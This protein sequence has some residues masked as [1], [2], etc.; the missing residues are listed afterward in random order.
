MQIGTD[1]IGRI[2]LGTAALSVLVF[3]AGIALATQDVV[4]TAVKG[5]ASIQDRELGERAELAEDQRLQTGDDGG[6]SVL[7]DRSAVVEL[8]GRTQ[9]SF[10]RD[11]KRGN[12][13]VNVE[14]GDLRLV[15]EPREANERIEI[16]TPA[17]IA[18]ILGTVVY[19]SVD[20]VTGATTISSSESRVNI[21]A[22]DEVECSPRGMPPEPGTPECAEGATIGSLEQL[23]VTPGERQGSVKKLSQ[24]Q[25]DELGGCLLDFRDLALD[26]DRRSQESRAVARVADVDMAAS[27]SLPFAPGESTT[28]SGSESETDTEA[29]PELQPTDDPT[30]EEEIMEEFM[31]EID[32]PA[33][34]P[35]PVGEGCS[36]P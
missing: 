31:N 13:I 18:T 19:I 7:L 20:P 36:F 1:W 28:E 29:E 14:S 9:L 27:E 5:D 17:A 10:G 12:R 32:P 16:H 15:V 3:G 22:R 34:G 25:V 4:L 23:T 2:F 35:F 6:C 26:A 33:C 8:C 21:R 11:A 24:Q 30:Q